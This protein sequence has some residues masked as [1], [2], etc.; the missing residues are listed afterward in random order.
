[1]KNIMF[2]TISRSSVA[3]SCCEFSPAHDLLFKESLLLRISASERIKK[4]ILRGFG[5]GDLRRDSLHLAQLMPK[6]LKLLLVFCG[7]RRDLRRC[8]SSLFLELN[9]ESLFGLFK[10]IFAFCKLILALM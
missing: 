1:M 5:R 9:I 7:K 6:I 3:N 8:L 4:D 2:I 10:F